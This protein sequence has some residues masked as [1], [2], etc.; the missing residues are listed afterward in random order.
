[1][2]VALFIAISAAFFVSPAAGDI[3]VTKWVSK[4][5]SFKLTG[6]H[7]SAVSAF[8]WSFRTSAASYLWA[9]TG[10]DNDLAGNLTLWG[11]PPRFADWSPAGLASAPVQKWRFATAGSTALSILMSPAGNSFLAIADDNTV[12]LFGTPATG[13]GVADLRNW[14]VRKTWSTSTVNPC[15][16]GYSIL[17]AGWSPDG[18]WLL[19]PCASANAANS[20]LPTS[21]SPY[22]ALLVGSSASNDATTWSMTPV[23]TTNIGFTKSELQARLMLCRCQPCMVRRRSD[24]MP[25][26]PGCCACL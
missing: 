6:G 14:T 11:G 10:A 4:P 26:H 5:P 9:V 8:S 2:P 25:L 18:K 13:A 7:M 22:R 3:D 16:A 12:S 19:M 24:A 1:M 20:Y 21:T 17:S 23:S 15:P